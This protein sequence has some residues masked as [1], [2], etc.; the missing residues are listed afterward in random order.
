MLTGHAR[1]RFSFSF[2]NIV[3]VVIRESVV[4]PHS[5]RDF[6]GPSGEPHVAASESASQASRWH[7]S[8]A[9][10]ACWSGQADSTLDLGETSR[11]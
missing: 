3:I 5:K 10:G 2:R 11:C 4:F 8:L 9:G 6:M 1:G 7:F